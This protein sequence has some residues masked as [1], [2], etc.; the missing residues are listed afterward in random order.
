MANKIR[1]GLD[2]GHGFPDVHNV[3]P[4]G[5]VEAEGTLDMALACR[6]EL[7]RLGYD[8]CMTRMSK[9]GLSLTGRCNILN[10]ARVDYAVSIH[11]NATGD[12]NVR[13]VETIYSI[14]HA[15]TKDGD[16]LAKTVAD[17][18]TR[19][20]GLPLRRMFDR[21]SVNYPGN[22]YYTLIDKTAM[23]CIIA[24]VAFHS[25]P[26]EEALLKDPLFRK[27]A[28]QAIAHGIDAFIK[29]KG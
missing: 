8:V 18:L 27:R 14:H 15:K 25:N 28:G 7:L 2:A 10:Q 21:E 1:I 22:D 3:G 17:A 19:E 11:S 23:T 5:Y 20:L 26:K 13:G 12:P 16:E 6:E 4:T 24:E 29:M 9:Q